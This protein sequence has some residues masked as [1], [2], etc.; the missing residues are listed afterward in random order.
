VFNGTLG[1]AAWANVMWLFL[2]GSGEITHGDLSDLADGCFTAYGDN[3]MPLVSD[4]SLL[5]SCQIVLY[6]TGDVFDATSVGAIAGA[7]TTGDTM[8]ANVAACISWHIA[9]HYRGGHPRSYLAGIGIASLSSPTT[10]SGSF[11][12]A[13]NSAAPAFHSDLEALGPIGSGITTVEHGIVSFVVDNDWR[14]PPVFRRITDGVVDS[15]VDS[16]RRRL[17]RDRP[18]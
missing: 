15:R 7:G 6:E 13:A 3:L 4:S 8:P 12:A 9:S 2:T 17:G 10:L 11:L 14:S 18:A 1:D 16:Q 5:T